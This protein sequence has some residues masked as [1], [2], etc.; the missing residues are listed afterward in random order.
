MQREKERERESEQ[1]AGEEEETAEEKTRIHG[2]SGFAKTRFC[3]RPVVISCI[4]INRLAK[5]T[6]P[7]NSSPL[8][9]RFLGARRVWSIMEDSRNHR[10]IA[11]LDRITQTRDDR[12]L[13]NFSS[14]DQ[15]LR[16]LPR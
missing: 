1:E 15:Q 7:L 16:R 9:V 3:R 14:N 5:S 6:F 4:G 11:E 12:R 13:R 8:R 2:R 10:W